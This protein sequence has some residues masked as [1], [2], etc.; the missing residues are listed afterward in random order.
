[1]RI[2]LLGDLFH[3]DLYFIKVMFGEGGGV[4]FLRFGG[5]LPCSANL[6][7]GRCSFLGTR[8]R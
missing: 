1:M 6:A 3:Y 4:W 8:N 5:Q 2:A 7:A